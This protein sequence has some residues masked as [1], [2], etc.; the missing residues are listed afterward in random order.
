[1]SLGSSHAAV[2][3]SHVA[4]TVVKLDVVGNF[5]D[6]EHFELHDVT[7]DASIALTLP[8]VEEIL[9]SVDELL[10]SPRVYTR[11][12][13]FPWNL[14]GLKSLLKVQEIVLFDCVLELPV[15]QDHFI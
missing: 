3:L 1:M 8:V 13:F 7:L 6:L 2:G 15:T 4:N 10:N 14:E 9:Q 12:L 11:F 5:L